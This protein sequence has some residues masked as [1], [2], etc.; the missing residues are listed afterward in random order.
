[1]P[2]KK[3][4][5]TADNVW[6]VTRIGLGLV[7]FG[8]FVDKLIGMGFTTCRD[9]ATNTINVMCDSA[10]LS[11]GSPTTGFLQFGTRGP[12]A[13]FYQSLAG[14]PLV[15]WLFMLG[16]LGIGLAL[17]LGIGMRIATISG[18][19]LFLMMYTATIPPTNN[20]IVSDHIIY[21]LVLVG[22]YLQNDKQRYG[23]GSKW[24][25]N[26]LVKKYPVLR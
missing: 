13:E 2:K 6:G 23:L 1:M 8:A 10:W 25:K 3:S 19:A 21:S 17:L 9:T 7:L 14:N 11:G 26:K 15:D 12:L 18:V 16:L 20:P 5:V 22:L 4:K 24:S